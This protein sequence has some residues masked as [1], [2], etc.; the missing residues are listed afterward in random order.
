M[1]RD[2]PKLKQSTRTIIDNEADLFVSSVVA[3]EFADLDRRGR[4]GSFIGLDALLEAF[5]ARVLG[6]PDGAWRL[7][8][9]LP[10]MHGDPIDRMLI[11]HAL[12]A[13]V[14]IVTADERISQYPVSTVWS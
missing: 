2:N 4:F 3:W 12:H 8:D 14:P 6:F 11:G 7:A 10:H 5:S 1:A 9:L 13:D